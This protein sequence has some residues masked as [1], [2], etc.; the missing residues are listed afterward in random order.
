VKTIVGKAWKFGDG[1]DTDIIIPA[2][3]LIL[4]LEEMKEKT[5][6]P[7][8]SGF[9][10]EF[11]PGGLIVAGKNF[12][13]GSSREQ[14][15]AVL[16]ALGV[17]AIVADS[18]ARIFFRNAINLGVPLVECPGI[19]RQIEEG[20]TVEVDLS[21]GKIRVIGQGAEFVGSV[22]PDFL[23]EILEDGGLVKHLTKG[24]QKTGGR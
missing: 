1:I 20:D 18:F 9:A 5:T 15:P 11:E 14:A 12:G 13:C 6:E 23:L 2:R 21:E 22:L 3:Y 24:D 19:S 16:K 7:L 8:R 17:S 10:A 4:P